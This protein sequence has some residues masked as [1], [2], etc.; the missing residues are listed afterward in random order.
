MCE[1]PTPVNAEIGDN[2]EQPPGDSSHRGCLIIFP[3]LWLLL[4]TPPIN[5]RA[6]LS[7]AW[8]LTVGTLIAIAI[9]A[10]SVRNRIWWIIVA[11]P[12]FWS[13]VATIILLWVHTYRPTL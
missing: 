6:S 4:A 13:L 7:V 10:G 12:L 1:S 5:G 9:L 11:V 3:I 2:P 8:A